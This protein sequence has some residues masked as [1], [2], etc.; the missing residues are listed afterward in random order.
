LFCL[1]PLFSVPLTKAGPHLLT[2]FICHFKI[3]IRAKVTY[4]CSTEFF[5]PAF[6]I[7]LHIFMCMCES[8]S[9]SDPMKSPLPPD[10]SHNAISTVTVIQSKKLRFILQIPKSF[11][12]L[13]PCVPTFFSHLSEF[14]HV[15]SLNLP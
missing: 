4:E 9:V 14:H 3:K 5:S 6:K 7:L 10:T 13:I 11:L 12:V 15:F 8:A 1:S 2:A